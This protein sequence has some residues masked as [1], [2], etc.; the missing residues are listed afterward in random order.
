MADQW[1]FHVG[2]E[3]LTQSD[4][5]YAPATVVNATTL[6]L[7]DKLAWHSGM[8]FNRWDKSWRVIY[9]RGRNA[10]LLERDFP[11]G[12]VVLATD[13]YFVSNEAM[14]RD[15]HADLL[16]WLIGPN[17]HVVFDES[18]LGIVDTGGIATLMRQYRLHG[19]LAGLILLA[20]LFIWKN[21]TSL[22]PPPADEKP[23][24]FVAGKDAAAG[25]VNL[26]R[27]NLAPRDL[28]AACF[29]EWKK[30]GAAGKFSKTRVQQAEAVFNSENSSA[31]KDRNPVGAY[32]QI[33]QILG[34]QRQKL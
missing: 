21:S 8:V 33:S 13:S 29:T 16:A 7:P 12:S 31:G 30:S 2:F 24:P 28:L 25:F 5:T 11:H 9:G 1:N 18:H 6:P 3:G 19:L 15:R 23:E 27:R 34:S 10:V 4:D 26:L 14:E 32:R 17:S 22:V 20:G